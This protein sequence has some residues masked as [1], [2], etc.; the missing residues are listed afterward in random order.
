M[1]ILVTGGPVHGY[2]DPVKIVTNR[3][4]G[5]LMLALAEQLSE[6]HE[7]TYVC[8]RKRVTS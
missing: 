7:V 8:K 5:G 6:Q 2:L 1:K 4:R 3:F